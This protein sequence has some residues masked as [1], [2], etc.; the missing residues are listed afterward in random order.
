[1]SPSKTAKAPNV[2]LVGAGGVG[3][4]GCVALESA[5]AHVTAV[6]RSNYNTVLKK[7]Y[8]IDSLDYG[9]LEGW[10]PSKS[11]ASFQNSSHI[12]MLIIIVVKTVSEGVTGDPFDYVVVVMKN[13]PDVYSIA[14]II[15]PA[16]SASTAIVLIQN[17]IG[18]EE[19]LIAAFPQNIV[20][21]AVSMI[22]AHN[23]DGK[24]LH[25]DHDL[26]MLGTVYNPNLPKDVQDAAVQAFADL[27]GATKSTA[28]VHENITWARWR[29]L[30][31]NASFNTNCAITQLDSAEIR[32]YG[33]EY[34]VIRPCM[35]E[36]IAIAKADGHILPDDVMDYMIATTPDDLKFRPSMLVDVDKGNPVEVEVILG[37]PIRTARKLGVETPVLDQTYRLLKLVQCRLLQGKGLI[38]PP[39]EIPTTD[40]I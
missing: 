16:V 28:Q 11:T 8:T 21:S 26:I 10:R 14:D 22:G 40:F 5:G 23:W 32:Q 1:M 20:M 9:K 19:P 33:G 35:K 18:I 2:M 36:I 39:K 4:I 6:L 3:T 38:S 7:G 30:V 31:W 12:L 25:D 27:Y 24:I 17:G 15:K 37:N 13:T 29:K 34:S